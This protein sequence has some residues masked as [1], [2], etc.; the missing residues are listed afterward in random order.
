M[1]IKFVED[2]KIIYHKCFVS[3][4]VPNL[5]H[6]PDDVAR[7]G[8]LDNFSAFPFESHMSHIKK[9]IRN[10]N[11]QLAQ[12][13][14][15]TME[16]YKTNNISTTED[17]HYPRLSKEKLNFFHKIEYQHF[18]LQ[19]DKR[20]CWF[21]TEDLKIFQ[22][23]KAEKYE[24]GIRIYCKQVKCT[25]PLF[26]KPYDSKNV[27]CFQSDGLISTEIIPNNTTFSKLFG[28]ELHD[29]YMFMHLVHT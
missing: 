2:F 16:K 17:R 24:N 6:L 12:V 13:V 25:A 20:N 5:I 14:I 11:K 4:N 15:R 1:L 22:F 18:F 21:L 28:M 23:V 27:Y 7:Y 8:N 26:L 19:D 9:M 3:H 10:A 29:K